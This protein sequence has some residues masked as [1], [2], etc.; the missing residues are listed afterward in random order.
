[1]ER[2]Q[3]LKTALE[4]GRYVLGYTAILAGLFIFLFRGT[5]PSVF[6][7]AMGSGLIGGQWMIDFISSWKK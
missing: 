6:F 3:K 1:M 4:I 5:E 7:W 2:N